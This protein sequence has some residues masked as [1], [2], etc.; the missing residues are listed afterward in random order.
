[1]FTFGVNKFKTLLMHLLWSTETYE[2]K[3]LQT[4]STYSLQ[5][6]GRT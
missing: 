2:I 5:S 1:M 6:I 3:R 4:E